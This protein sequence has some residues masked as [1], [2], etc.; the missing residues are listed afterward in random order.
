VTVS[1]R[2]RRTSAPTQRY[3]VGQDNDGKESAVFGVL[4][5]DLLDLRVTE[6]GF[7]NALYASEEDPESCSSCSCSWLCISLCCTI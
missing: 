7:R 3:V 2:F 4:T 6:K 1:A 5:E